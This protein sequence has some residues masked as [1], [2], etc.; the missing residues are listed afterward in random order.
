M[1]IF[2]AISFKVVNACPENRAFWYRES[3]VAW[4]R[5]PIEP[6]RGGGLFPD[7]FYAA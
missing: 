1:F 3:W 4:A 2:A 7:P 5:T 6:F